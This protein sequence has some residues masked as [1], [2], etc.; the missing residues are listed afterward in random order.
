MG[1]WQHASQGLR[2]HSLMRLMR[3]ARPDVA[4]LSRTQRL[5]IEW[6]ALRLGI[7][8]EQSQRRYFDS[9]AA[10][11]NGHRGREFR[12]LSRVYHQLL[13]V[14]ADDSPEEL[15]QAYRMHEP[16]HFLAHLG[17]PEV[18]FDKGEP[19]VKALSDRPAATIIDFGA[20][21]AYHS[22]ALARTLIDQNV[23]TKLVLV[24]LPAIWTE[25]VLWIG[26]RDK[27]P[28]ELRTGTEQQPIPELPDA[29][30]CVA[31]EFFE[32]VHEPLT[33]FEPLHRALKPG[34]FFVTN[35]EDH[36]L[37]FMH[38]SPSLATI[39]QRLEQ[40][41]YEEVESFRVFRKPR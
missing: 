12:W 23:A 27:I 30:I 9:W 16:M 22:R 33:Y 31:T 11:P 32:H 4:A 2:K 14:F 35:V 26:K 37:E 10:V 5:F 18:E 13:S 20:G 34:G 24:D 41:E 7:D 25:F 1:L 3:G 19:I 8:E 36:K 21:L 6:N 28:M 29:E 17:L 15:R 38:V 40:L 39:R